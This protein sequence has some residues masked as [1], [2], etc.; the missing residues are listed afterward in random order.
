MQISITARHIDLTDEHKEYVEK[1]LRHL[2][3]FF[4]AIMDC[5]VILAK[6]KHRESADVTIQVMAS[7]C[8][9]RRR[10]KIF[11]LDR[12]GRG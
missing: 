1:R 6:E 3:R 11:S 12:S 2:K 5:H 7:P 8:T 9:G 10:R 4:D